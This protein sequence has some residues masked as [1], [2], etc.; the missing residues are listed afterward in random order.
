MRR[1]LLL[2][3]AKAAH[4]AGSGDRERALVERG[5]RD[6]QRVGAFLAAADL[7]PDLT[8]H[9]GA[10]RARQTAAIVVDAWPRANEARA[11][12]GLYEAAA[13]GLHAIVRALPDAAP[14]VMLV[15][16][17]PS[18]A[19]LANTLVGRGDKGEMLRMAGKFPTAGLAV[20]EFDV[21]RWRDVAPGSARL[22]RFA[23]PDDLSG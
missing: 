1:L 2:R 22:T 16:H 11:D 17:N 7:V 13:A 5:R 9:S 6:A 18:L 10:E 14:S 23:T 20:L 4:P 15:G 8:I 3:H 21:D 19:D 12:P